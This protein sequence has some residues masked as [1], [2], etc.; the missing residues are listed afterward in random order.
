MGKGSR[1][2]V[3][4]PRR[5]VIQPLPAVFSGGDC[6]AC[7]LAGLGGFSIGEVYARFT[8]K[9]VPRPFTWGGFRRALTLM[10]ARGLLD[11][12][13]LDPP[14]WIPVAR[15]REWGITG[16]SVAEEWFGYVRLA[17]DGGYYGVCVV[18]LER[19]GPLAS[20]DHAILIRGVRELEGASLPV[21]QILVSDPAR[22]DED[23]WSE[24]GAFLRRRGGF[25]ILLARPAR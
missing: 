4:L 9:G 3:V 1:D 22:R 13:L 24:V 11:R 17:L 16:W 5:A 21:N 2:E 6:G 25:N 7:V 15:D 8:H 10:Y 12:V 23:E 19:K 20:I 18:D 14:L